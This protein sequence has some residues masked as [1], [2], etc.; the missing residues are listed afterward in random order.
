MKQF[1]LV[2]LAILIA[3]GVGIAFASGK[4]NAE[5]WFDYN[6]GSRT[7]D[8]HYY[9]STE[10]FISENS[11]GDTLGGRQPNDIELVRHNLNQSTYGGGLSM[12]YGPIMG[13]GGGYYLNE[14]SKSSLYA[15]MSLNT[16]SYE[17]YGFGLDMGLRT[18]YHDVTGS[19]L[20]PYAMPFVV[21]RKKV[22]THMTIRT[23]F[24]FEPKMCSE[25][26][27]ALRVTMGVG[28]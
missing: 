13:F 9:T 21:L 10:G 20:S 12:D 8:K 25:C 16:P 11:I 15:F 27:G 18:G 22:G 19:V 26:N 6:V 7:N 4:A 5:L 2:D 24:G 28:L 17:P 23:K 1:T 14:Y 3:V